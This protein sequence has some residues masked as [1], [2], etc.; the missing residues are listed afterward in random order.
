MTLTG[1][2]LPQEIILKFA[3][4]LVAVLIGLSFAFIAPWSTDIVANAPPVISLLMS[5]VKLS[6]KRSVV[7]SAVIAFLI[8]PWWAFFRAPAIVDYT[9]AWAANY[10]ILLGPIAGIM[11]AN[12]WVARKG[13]Y[14]VQKLYTFGPDGPWYSQGWSKAAYVSLILTWILC[15]LIAWPTDQIVTVGF[16]PFP[17]G[18]IWYPAVLLSFILYLIFAQKVFQE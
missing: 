11:V 7:V 8:A 13:R 1:T 4:G 14:D 16:F 9:T 15:Y 6:W 3:P 17:G 5:Q 10:G 18:I 2:V 12:Y